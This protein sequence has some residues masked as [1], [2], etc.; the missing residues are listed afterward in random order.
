MENEKISLYEKREFT[1]RRRRVPLP[2]QYIKGPVARKNNSIINQTLFL[3]KQFDSTFVVKAGDV[4]LARFPAGVGC[5]ISGDHFVVAILDSG[6]LNPLVLVVPLKSDKGRPINPA[7]DIKIGTVKG[8]NNNKT[9]IAV[10]NQVRAIDKRRLVNETSIDALHS[11]FRKNL[12]E[13]YKDT[14]VQRICVYRLSEKQFNVLRN[15]V[16][17]YVI[18]NFV[19]HDEELLVDF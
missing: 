6:P 11:L 10:I 14:V 4:F 7:S 19:S 16:I 1:V 9:S 17:R 5:E 15:T 8:I 3:Y 13:E 12:V 2:H 18:S